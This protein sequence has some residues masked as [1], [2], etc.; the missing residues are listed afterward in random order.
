M[1]AVTRV[2]IVVLTVVVAIGL[3]AFLGLGPFERHQVTEIITEV[4]PTLCPSEPF[5]RC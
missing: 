2:V 1:N 4:S 5:V 3:A